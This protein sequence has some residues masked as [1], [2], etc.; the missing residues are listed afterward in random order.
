M[1]AVVCR[2]GDKEDT[3]FSQK[4]VAALRVLGDHLHSD[5]LNFCV[6]LQAAFSPE[7][8]NSNKP[9]HFVEIVM[10]TTAIK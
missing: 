8:G 2:G 9:D 5:G 3:A 1:V 6:L 4:R 7:T 10:L